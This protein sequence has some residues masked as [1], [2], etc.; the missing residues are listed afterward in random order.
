MANKP[1]IFL[2]Q[3]NL[4]VLAYC[5]EQSLLVWCLNKLCSNTTLSTR[6]ARAYFMMMGR[7]PIVGSKFALVRRTD[8][9]SQCL[10]A[11]TESAKKVKIFMPGKKVIA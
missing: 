5:S 4:A 10:C 7:P 9:Q 6:K 8:P 2:E 11:G 3:T 1:P